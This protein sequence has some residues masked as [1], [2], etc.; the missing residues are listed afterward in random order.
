MGNVGTKFE[1]MLKEAWLASN[2]ELV[3][4]KITE[5]G[6]EKPCDE[7]VDFAEYRVFNELKSTQ[8]K[9]FDLKQIKRH[10]LLSLYNWDKKFKDSIGLVSIEYRTYNISYIIHIID[11]IKHGKK[12]DKLTTADIENMKHYKAPFNNKKGTYD[13]KKDFLKFL[14]E[15]NTNKTNN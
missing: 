15:V 7:R 11:I 1:A 13:I 8:N 4:M 3:R 9:S 10:Q 14:Q 6:E 2:L 12:T 5:T